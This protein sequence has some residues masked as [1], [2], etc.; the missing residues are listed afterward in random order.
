[1]TTTTGWLLVCLI[2][3]ANSGRLAF[4]T[5]SAQIPSDHHLRTDSA[6]IATLMQQA[7]ERS[8]TFQRLVDA[9]NASD[10]IV[11][12]E[13]GTCAQG[14][15]ACFMNVTMAGTHRIL[16]VKVDTRGVDCDLMGMIG[17]ELQH[18]V[19]V[20]RDAHVTGFATMYNFYS[21]EANPGGTFP[22]E[23]IGAKR[24][25]EAVRAEVR[26][27]SSCAKMR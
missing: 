22:F 24:I 25:G 3:I 12:V 15:R 4:A 16:W 19:E 17:H 26:R 1:M 21:R 10:G 7:S 5:T 6:V 14:R 13:Q 2:A 18:T 8:L 11:Y 20:L 27:K 23:T 9:I